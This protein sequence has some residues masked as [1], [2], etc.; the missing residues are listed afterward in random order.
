MGRT[1]E[2][3]GEAVRA[4]R[5]R[6]G[7]RTQ[8]LADKAECS[9][10]TVESVE[11]GN[12]VYAFTLSQIAAALGEPT[13]KLVAGATMPPPQDDMVRIT[14]ELAFPFHKF[15]QSDQLKALITFMQQ[16]T[17][18]ELEPCALRESSV[19]IDLL[20][21]KDDL[22][23]LV[24][25]FLDLKLEPL[26]INKLVS[27]VIDNE[28]LQVLLDIQAFSVNHIYAM[29]SD[30]AAMRFERKEPLPDEDAVDESSAARTSSEDEAAN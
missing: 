12:A 21:H 24:Q 23:K 16:F 1:V 5:L 4:A 7:W 17:K 22:Y 2:P 14:V 3:N 9:K 10:R 25:A 27:P 29:S 19:S 6:K 30:G 26:R 15:D 20:L 13:E 11:A 8:D 28:P 18:G